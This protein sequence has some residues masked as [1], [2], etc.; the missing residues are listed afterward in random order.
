MINRQKL[1]IFC[2]VQQSSHWLQI[3]LQTVATFL[4]YRNITRI[5]PVSKQLNQV[6]SCKEMHCKLD[7][8]CCRLTQIDCS[9]L[10]ICLQLL[11]NHHQSVC[12]PSY[13]SRTAI[14]WREVTSNQAI[15]T[16]AM[17]LKVVTTTVCKSLPAEKY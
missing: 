7:I 4:L 9:M 16:T 5:Q 13:L 11:L 15:C 8:H 1:Q 14:G 12:Y 17:Q 2:Y 6:P 10:A 3:P